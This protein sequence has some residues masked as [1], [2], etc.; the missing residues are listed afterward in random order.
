MATTSSR[1]CLCET[2]Q[3][4]WCGA[5]RC[6]ASRADRYNLVDLP[7]LTARD[8]LEELQRHTGM[9]LDVRYRSIFQFY[10][11]DLAKWLVKLLVRHPDRGRVPSYRDWES[12]TQKAI[13]DCSR[14][15]SELAWT[16]ASD[17]QRIIDEGIGDALQPW[18]EAR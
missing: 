15:R 7:L 5:S 1:L 17:R 2:L 16:P 3:Q 11:T 4:R 12:R 13:F 10:L 18:L 14:A 6:L 8:Y 9:T